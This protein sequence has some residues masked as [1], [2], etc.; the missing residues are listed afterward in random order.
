VTLSAA[1]SVVADDL[2]MNACAL[3]AG[4]DASGLPLNAVAIQK[5]RFNLHRK[6]YSES[7]FGQ[8]RS[9]WDLRVRNFPHRSIAL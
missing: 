6:I 5:R 3:L 9:A 4:G 2:N 7:G 8:V 1:S